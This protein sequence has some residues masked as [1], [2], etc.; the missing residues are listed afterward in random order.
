M[1]YV[2][3]AN[4]SDDRLHFVPNHNYLYSCSIQLLMDLIPLIQYETGFLK[5][6]NRTTHSI[7]IFH[8]RFSLFQ[9]VFGMFK[10]KKFT[11]V[12]E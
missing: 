8:A 10:F 11:V 6:K 9:I 2:Q 4:G 7:M 3:L 5:K 12:L 1:E